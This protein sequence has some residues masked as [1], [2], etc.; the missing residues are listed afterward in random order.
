MSYAV[1]YTMQYKGQYTPRV[2][3]HA[4]RKIEQR[5]LGQKRHGCLNAHRARGRSWI[6]GCFWDVFIKNGPKKTV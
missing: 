5:M 4:Q 3:Q 2:K 6:H 1:Q